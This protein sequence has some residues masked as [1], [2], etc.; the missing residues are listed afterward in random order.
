[1]RIFVVGARGIPNVEGGAEKNAEALFPRVVASG[2][3]VRLFGLSNHIKM[4]NYKGVHLVRGAP[5]W[6][7]KTEKLLYY[8]QAIAEALRFRPDIVHLQGLGAAVFLWLYKLLGYKVVVRYGSADYLLGKWGFIG[9][10]AFR[11]CE[12]QLRFADAIISV[13][14]ALT[15]RLHEK[16][17]T[18]NIHD[19]PNAVD[20]IEADGAAPTAEERPFILAV[21]RVTG[22]KN[23]DTLIRSFLLFKQQR[24]DFRLLVAGGLDDVEYVNS[25]KELVGGDV[26]LLGKMNRGEVAF[27][28]KHCALYTNLSHHEGCSNATLEAIGQNCP[29]L[30]SDIPENRD[31]KLQDVIFTDKDDPETIAVRMLHAVSEPDQFRIREAGFLTWDDVA[32]RT[33]NIYRD[34]STNKNLVLEVT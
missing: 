21:G 17:I 10:L 22:Q 27:L 29:I 15:A 14:P 23:I 32:Q 2:Y 25:L 24:P 30:L 12:F 19:V 18:R 1:M 3:E 13:A 8:I 11:F 5:F 31:M 26:V 4:D 7:L 34:I 20:R 6:L 9:K 28:L 33:M 16:G